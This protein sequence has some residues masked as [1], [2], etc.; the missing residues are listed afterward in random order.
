ARLPKGYFK[1]MTH[2]LTQPFALLE[3]FFKIRFL[4]LVV[5]V[6]GFGVK[7]QPPGIN[8]KSLPARMLQQGLVNPQGF[9]VAHALGQAG[10]DLAF[11]RVT[12]E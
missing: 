10:L 5:P 7:Q 3:V 6:D 12:D 2:P 1:R 8:N 11:L 4:P 9:F